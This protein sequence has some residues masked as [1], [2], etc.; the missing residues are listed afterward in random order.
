MKL[1]QCKAAKFFLHSL[2]MESQC[3]VVV[4]RNSLFLYVLWK[5]KQ[6]PVA[7]FQLQVMGVVD[8]IFPILWMLSYSLLYAFKYY[9]VVGILHLSWNYVCVSTYP[10]MFMSQSATIWI[11][12]L[13]AV[14]RYISICI[15]YR[16]HRW[17]ILAKVKRWTF[18]GFTVF[19][20]L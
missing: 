6:S 15:S 17:V 5:D 1:L 2:S 16:A 7:T 14:I 13:M 19:G 3:F 12:I 20:S 4:E 10:M 18:L 8:S 9:D 11:T